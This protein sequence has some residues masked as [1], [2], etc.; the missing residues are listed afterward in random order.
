MNL[1]MLWFQYVNRW[2]LNKLEEKERRIHIQQERTGK[3]SLVVPARDL[4]RI[5]IKWFFQC[6]YTILRSL[7]AHRKQGGARGKCTMVIHLFKL[8]LLSHLNIFIVT[9]KIIGFL[10]VKMK[11][12]Q[13]WNC[14]GSIIHCV[15]IF[16]SYNIL[17]KSNKRWAH[18]SL[19]ISVA[20]R[21]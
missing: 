14:K 6:P 17:S 8:K 21:N 13:A 19:W 4:H 11:L 12:L 9:L 18:T 20:H 1:E 3:A 7:P 5:L 2:H 10:N 15:R 16:F